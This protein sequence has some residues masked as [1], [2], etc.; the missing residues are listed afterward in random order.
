MVENKVVITL[1]EQ[2]LLE[3]Q[4]I[5]I[6]NDKDGALSFVKTCLMKKIPIKG[7]AMCDSTRKNPF[8]RGSRP[9]EKGTRTDKSAFPLRS[10]KGEIGNK[11]L[12]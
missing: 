1:E 3:L 7:T 6:D 5:V 8:L 10:K 11:D 9:D 4:E 2:D 12:D